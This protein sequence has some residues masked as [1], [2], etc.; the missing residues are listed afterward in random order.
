MPTENEQPSIKGR[1]ST[2]NHVLRYLRR[3]FAWG[4]RHGH[5]K[6][7]PA[8][9]VRQV[10]E[11]EQFRMPSQET[12][13]AV[14]DFAYERGT[15]T[16]HTVGS[17]APYLAPAVMVLAYKMRLR[18]IEV[19]TLNDFHVTPKGIRT[20]RRKGSQDNLTLLG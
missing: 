5:V 14:L 4:I 16:A 12:D 17:V 15:R 8:R 1:P 11:R 3:T 6:H 7:N 9:G 19:V 18:G 13:Q 2:A 20:N 10:E